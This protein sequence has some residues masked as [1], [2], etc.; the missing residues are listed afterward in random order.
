MNNPETWYRKRYALG[1]GIIGG[2]SGYGIAHLLK[3]SSLTKLVSALAGAG[4]GSIAG[5]QIGKAKDIHRLS[6]TKLL[7]GDDTKQRIGESM[8]TKDMFGRIAVQQ[9]GYD[10]EAFDA[11]VAADKIITSKGDSVTNRDT[12][13]AIANNANYTKIRLKQIE[14]YL[15]TSDQWERASIFGSVYRNKRTNAIYDLGQYKKRLHRAVPQYDATLT[16]V[17]PFAMDH[18]MTNSPVGYLYDSLVHIPTTGKTRKATMRLFNQPGSS[19]VKALSG[20]P[21]LTTSSYATPA[22]GINNESSLIGAVSGHEYNHVGSL[23]ISPNMLPSNI[24]GTGMG[25]KEPYKRAYAVI[26]AEVTQHLSALNQRY[27]RLTGDY[28]KD[29]ESFYRAVKY[30]AKNIRKVG[31]EGRRTLQMLAGLYNDSNGRP[32]LERALQNYAELAPVLI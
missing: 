18:M 31:P 4:I 15:K 14:N 16:Q 1:G 5:Y 20:T 10:D 30:M 22:M 7:E 6:D 21:G 24:P 11:G 32:E 26:P 3:G 29:K 2:A 17:G 25:M 19:I 13:N 23:A 12:A 9:S 28:V 8:P 27:H